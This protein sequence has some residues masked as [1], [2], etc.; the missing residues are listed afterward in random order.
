MDALTTIVLT[1]DGKSTIE[2]ETSFDDVQ[3]Y[4]RESRLDEGQGQ[5]ID[6]DRAK[7]AQLVAFLQSWLDRPAVELSS[8]LSGNEA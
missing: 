4:I 3:I 6:L 1:T 7:V 5:L 2:V 8:L